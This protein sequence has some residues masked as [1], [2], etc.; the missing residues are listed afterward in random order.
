MNID[1]LR[2]RLLS[3]ITF[4]KVK[5]HYKQKWQAIKSGEYLKPIIEYRDKIVYQDKVVYKDKVVYQ[6]KKVFVPIDKNV[7]ELLIVNTDSIGDYIIFRNF[8]KEIKN[9]EKYKGYKITLLGSDVFKEF[10]EYLDSD[11]VDTFLWSKPRAQEFSTEDKNQLKSDLHNRQGMKYFYDTIIYSSYNSMAKREFLDFLVSEIL[12]NEKVIHHDNIINNSDHRKSTEML[13]YTYVYRNFKSNTMFEFDINKCFFEDLINEKIHLKYPVIEPRK[14]KFCYGYLRQRTREYVAINPCAFDNFRMWNPLNWVKIIKYIYNEKELDVIIVCSEKEKKYCESITEL[15][16]FN[17]DILAGLPVGKLLAT[18]KAA[19]MYI[20]QDSGIFHVAAALG[21]RSL[22]LS[23]GNA[24]FRFMNYPKSRKNVK[25]LFPEGTEE[26]IWANDE[27]HT[28]RSRGINA[29]YINSIKVSELKK[30]IDKFLKIKDITFI[31]KLR[32]DNTGDLVLCPYEHFME[33]FDQY[34]V[35][36]FDIDDLE[37]IPFR[38]STYIL[39]GGGL[40]NQN[41]FWNPWVNQLLENGSRLIG[42][43]IGF[44]QHRDH[45]ITIPMKIDSFVLL[46]IR[47]YNQKYAWL[48]CVSCLMP[49]LDEQKPSK[50]KIGCITHYESKFQKFDCETIYNNEPFEKIIEFIAETEILITNTYHMIYWAT[51]MG[52][53]VILFDAFSSR[54]DNIKYP[55][56][57]YSGDLEKDIAEART[58]PEALAECREANLA[59]FEKVKEVIEL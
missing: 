9:S 47:D 13:S 57:R 43:G 7:K 36:K 56:T 2:Y 12:F 16:D 30:E 59:F 29:F 6:E 44:N 18:I 33:Y 8:L 1:H 58:Y 49:E 48:P 10:A 17:V 51:L 11:I 32:T 26:W 50:R 42:W 4:G 55:P 14:V 53:K 35:Q 23:A 37:F 41:N 46:G 19:R 5:K 22:C 21:T 34:I 52:K 27:N 20:G 40:I 28:E 31:H 39:G 25:V 54:F 24:Y 3:H 15:L 38:K 45:E